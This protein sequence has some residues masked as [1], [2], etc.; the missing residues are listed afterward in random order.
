MVE[1]GPLPVYSRRLR[2]AREAYGVM[3]GL[4]LMILCFYIARRDNFP[5]ISAVEKLS[6]R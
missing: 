4:S 3:L 6:R 5:P 2:E 1:K